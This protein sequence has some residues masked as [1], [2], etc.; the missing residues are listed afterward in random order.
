MFRLLRSHSFF[1]SLT[2]IIVVSFL[3]RIYKITNPVADW[4]SFRQA[5]TASVTREY[6]K[7]GVDFLRPKYQDLSNIQSGENNQGRDNVEGWRMVEFPLVNGLLAY[8]LRSFPSLDLVL[9]SRLASVFASLCS[10]VF[11]VLI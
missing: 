6:V 7:H 10:L 1:S 3:A 4:H 5:D 8:F 11:L 9:T 2:I